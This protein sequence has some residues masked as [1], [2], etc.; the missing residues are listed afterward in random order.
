MAAPN[1]ALVLHITSFFFSKISGT[2]RL[3]L[4]SRQLFVNFCGSYEY[5][6]ILSNANCCVLC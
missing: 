5:Y 3:L 4:L 1:P 6:C 2:C